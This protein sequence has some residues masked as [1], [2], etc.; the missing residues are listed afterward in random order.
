MKALFLVSFGLILFA[1]VAGAQ[2]CISGNVDVGES[3]IFYESAGKGGVLIFI[4]D[5]LVHREIWDEQFSYFSQKYK[6]V[7]YDRRGYGKSSEAKGAFSNVE[8]LLSLFTQL[9]IEK[10]CLIAMS[11]GGR[12]AIDFTLQSP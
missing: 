2:T 4:H 1:S 7:R 10:A 6:V 5:G 11:S 8:D 9:E 12:L 3:K